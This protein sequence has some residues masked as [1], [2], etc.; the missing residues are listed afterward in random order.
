MIREIVISNSP[1]ILY[2]TVDNQINPLNVHSRNPHFKWDYKIDTYPNSTKMGLSGY[3]IRVGTNSDALGTDEYIG[4]IWDTYQLTTNQAYEASL[5]NGE[6]FTGCDLT[7]DLV[8]GVIYYF[9]VQAYVNSGVFGNKSDWWVGSFKLNRPPT[10]INLAVVPSAPFNSDDLEAYYEFVDDPGDYESPLT[11]IRWYKNGKLVPSLNNKKVVPAAMTIPDDVW[12]FTVEPND[13]VEYGLVYTSPSTAP[14]LNRPPQ[15]SNLAIKPQVPR[16]SDILEASFSLSDPDDDPISATIKWYRNGVEVV[17]VRNSPTVPA[18]ETSYDDEWHFEIIPFDGYDYGATVRSAGVKVVNTPPRVASI[19]VEGQVFPTNVKS[20]NPTISW[21]YKDDDSQTQAA[22]RVVI[23]TKPLRMDVPGSREESFCGPGVDGILGTVKSIGNVAEGN[24]IFDS[25]VVTLGSSSLQYATNDYVPSVSVKAPDFQTFKGYSIQPDLQTISLNDLSGEASLSFTGQTAIYEPSVTYIR[26][27]GKKSLYRLVVDGSAVDDFISEPGTGPNTRTMKATRISADSKVSVVGSPVTPGALAPFTGLSFA[28]LREYD[29]SPSSFQTLSGYVSTEDGGISLV[30]TSGNATTLF[31]LP[32]GTYNIDIEYVTEATVPT[33]TIILSVRSNPILTLPYELGTATRTATVPDVT[34]NTGDQI[35]ISGTRNGGASSARVSKLTFT[36]KQTVATGASLNTGYSYYVAVSVYD[37]IDWSDWATSRFSM[38]GSA[39]SSVSNATGWTIEAKFKLAAALNAAAAPAAVPNCE[40]DPFQGLR[41][42]D[43]T[44]FGYLRLFPDKVQLLAEEPLEYSLDGS[45]YHL[46]RIA[47]MGTDISVYVD[48]ALA[49]DGTGKFTKQTQ[50]RLIEFGDIAGR[51]QT[52]GSAWQAF[53]VSTLGAYAPG[54]MRSTVLEDVTMFPEASVSK[55]K[56]YNDM[57]YVAVDPANPDSST[58]VYRF[59]EG[60][61]AEQRPVLA[62]TRSNVTAVVIDPNKNGN[63]FGTVGKYIGTELGLQYVLGGK[64]FPFDVST[65]MNILPEDNGWILDTNVADID[66]SRY[67]SADF[68]TISTL[69]ETGQKFLKYSQN[70]LGTEWVDKADNSE[71]W[72]V[73]VK[74]KVSDDGNGGN[75]SFQSAQASTSCDNTTPPDLPDLEALG[76]LI[77][78]GTREEV[79]QFFQNGI[80]LKNAKAFAQVDLSSEFTTVRIIGKNDAIAIFSKG[81]SQ[82]FFRRLIVSPD[83]MSTSGSPQ[84]DQERPSV[85]IDMAGR[86]HA[87]WQDSCDGNFAIKYAR[88]VPSKTMAE[89][90]LTSIGNLTTLNFD[91][92]RSSIGLPPITLVRSELKSTYVVS[93]TAS[94]LN[95]GNGP[96]SK[97]DEIIIKDSSGALKKYKVRSVPNDIVVDLD[98]SDDLSLSFANSEFS[99]GSGTGRTWSNSVV[100]SVEQLDST[101]PRLLYHSSGDLFVVY[102]NDAHGSRDVYIRRGKVGIRDTAWDNAIRLTSVSGD[103]SSPDIAEGS[104]G[105]ILVFWIG[106]GEDISTTHVFGAKLPYLDFG[107]ASASFEATPNSV[108]AKNIRVSTVNG[109]ATK[110]SSIIL[111]YQDS[112][113]TLS[114]TSVYA[115]LGSDSDKASLNFGTPVKISNSSGSCKNPS[116]VNCDGTLFYAAW[117]DHSS[118]KPEIFLCKMVATGTTTLLAETPAAITNSCGSSKNPLVLYS[119]APYVL[120]DNDRIRE[121]YSDV[122]ISM[123]AQLPLPPTMTFDRVN[124]V[125]N[126]VAAAVG[127]YKVGL[128][129]FNSV[130]SSTGSVTINVVDDPA[131]LDLGTNLNGAGASTGL[132]V[133]YSPSSVTAVL[134]QQFVYT[135]LAKNSPTAFDV[136]TDVVVSSGGHGLDLR[137][138]SYLGD[139]RRPAAAFKDGILNMVWEARKDGGRSTVYGA[140]H[141]GSTQ[142]FD[143]TVTAYFPLDDD[144]GSNMVE[145]KA[146]NFQGAP[147]VEEAVNGQCFQNSSP[148]GTDLYHVAAPKSGVSLYSPSTEGAFNLGVQGRSFTVPGSLL[149][150]SGAIDLWITP[151]WAS[152]SPKLADHIFFGNASLSDTTSNTLCC[153]VDVLNNFRLRI[154]DA[155]AS[156]NVHETSIA[157][158]DYSWAANESFHLRAVWDENASGVSSLNSTIIGLLGF[159]ATGFACGANGMIFKTTD[160]GATWTRIKTGVTYD[161][162]SIDFVD[163][164]M[165]MACGEYGTILKTSDGGTTWTLLDTGTTADLNGIILSSTTKACAVGAG[166]A[167]YTATGGASWAESAMPAAWVASDLN[168]ISLASSSTMVAVGENGTILRSTNYGASFSLIASPLSVGLNA[169]SRTHQGGAYTTYVVGDSGT[170]MKTINAGSSWTELDI[171]WGIV[172]PQTLLGVSHAASSNAVYVVGGDGTLAKSSDSGGTWSLT[173]TSLANGSFR[174]VEAN[175]WGTGSGAEAVAVGSGGVVMTTSDSGAHQTYHTARSGNLTLYINGKEPNQTRTLDGP[176]AWT[177]TAIPSLVFGDYAVGGT[178]PGLSIFDEL[179]IYGEPP[180]SAANYTK[181]D[182][183]EA[184]LDVS[185]FLQ[186]QN[187][188]K[189]I[190]W[191]SL[192]Q[193][194]ATKSFWKSVKIFTHGS[195]EPLREFCWNAQLGLIDDVVRDISA[196]TG[197]LLWVATENGVSSFDMLAAVTDMDKWLNGEV[198]VSNSPDRFVNYIGLPYGG[199]TSVAADKAGN[200]WVGTAAGLYVIPNVTAAS[201]SANS[202]QDPL[203][204]TAAKT[205]SSLVKMTSFPDVSILTLRAFGDQVFVGTNAGLAIIT[206]GSSQTGTGSSTLSFAINYFTMNDGLPS[207]MVQAIAKEEQSGDVWVGTDKGLVR[208]V[209]GRPIHYDAS[210]GLPSMNIFS[211]A[212]DSLARKFVGT[213]GGMAIIDGTDIASFLPSDG[214]GTGAIQG[215]AID[216]E[217]HAWLATSTSLVES[218]DSQGSRM[219][220]TYDTNDGII[221]YKNITDFQRYYIL[222]GNIPSGACEKARVSV[223]VNGVR[224]GSGYEVDASVPWIMFDTPLGPSDRVQACVEKAWRKVYDFGLNKNRRAYATVK[225]TRNTFNLYKKSFSA[226]TVVLGGNS[227][228]GGRNAATMYTAFVAPLPNGN[229][230]PL[231]SVTTPANNSI[232]A[233]HAGTSVYY[234]VSEQIQ[235]LPTELSGVDMIAMPSTDSSNSST[236]YLQFALSAGAFVYVAYDSR[237]NSL[238]DWLKDFEAVE[239]VF[240]ATDMET[241][242]DASG[243]EKLYVSLAGTN[244]SVYSILNAPEICDISSSIALDNNPPTGCVTSMTAGGSTDTLTLTLTATDAVSGVADMQVSSNTDFTN[245]DSTPMGWTPFQMRYTLQLPASAVPVEQT[246]TDITGNASVMESIDN[247]VLVAIGGTLNTLDKATGQLTLLFDT[248]EQGISSIVKFG[249]VIAVSTTPN[250]KVFTWD[251]THPPVQLGVVNAVSMITFDNNLYIGTKTPLTATLPTETSGDIYI[252]DSTL[253]PTLFIHTLET[254][255]NCFAIFTGN[256]YWGTSNNEVSE[257]D[258]LATTTRNGHRHAFTVPAGQI[259]LT[260]ANGTTTVVNG[261]SHAIVNGV[262]QVADGHVHNLNGRNSGKVFK[263]SSVSGQSTIVHSDKDYSITAI[264]SNSIGTVATTTAPLMF[265]GT[266]PNSKILRYVPDSGVFIKSFNVPALGGISRLKNIG[267]TIYAAADKDIFYFDGTRWQFT[268]SAQDTVKDILGDGNGIFVL[269]GDNLSSTATNSTAATGD[270]SSSSKKT[271]HAYVRFRDAVGNVSSIRAADGSLIPCYAPTITIDTSTGNTT[272]GGS[273]GGDGTPVTLKESHRI[274]EVDDQAKVVF[275][276]TGAEVFLS[277]NRVEQEI[278]TYESEIFNGTSSLVQWESIAWDAVTPTGT[279]ITL[280][281]RTAATASGVASASYGLEMTNPTGND[282]TNLIGQFLQFRA[283]LTVN[284]PGVSSPE[285]RS[286][287]IRLKTSDATHYFTTNFKLPDNVVR[288]LLTYNGCINPPVTDVVFG[289]CGTDSTD[290]SDYYIIT[291]NRIFEL[292]TEQQQP[293]LRVGIKMISSPTSVPVVDEFALLVSLA[294]NAVARLGQAGTPGGTFP[295]PI[296]GPTR[297]VITEPVQ[298][299]VHTVQFDA[300]ITDQTAVN[301]QTSISGSHSHIIVAGVLQIAAGHTHRWT[302]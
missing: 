229:M 286:V 276:L 28:P 79:V 135:I 271:L 263:L 68:L 59:Q 80:R 204:S 112:A 194:V 243:D 124:G 92:V 100:L 87:A 94:F 20:G 44:S 66:A 265:I 13:G 274:V 201:Q 181:R 262:V 62:I 278:G 298:G 266:Y 246:I 26:E 105:S 260:Q 123:V 104:D 99:I 214:L 149:S 86:P 222:G 16:T 236:A 118:S 237:A 51:N 57:L 136:L 205:T 37:G 198:S 299:H 284:V 258:V 209:G 143:S 166:T 17:A 42:Y 32:S 73:E 148:I 235:T 9:Q 264:A 43:G 137:V 109:G 142:T 19:M 241:F 175:F 158:A 27:Q 248:G 212:T 213:A 14:V 228:R 63:P 189:R 67:L 25:G 106:T 1:T 139:N 164:S 296:V 120:Y 119:K 257:N 178:H 39:W 251:G 114:D 122:Y 256:L 40:S 11:K 111:T 199:A 22:F 185:G 267:G 125:I 15:A 163:A 288:G 102:D 244:G 207:N 84:G 77:N 36:P 295:Q 93:P 48:G 252:V 108:N 195:R 151:Y 287:D 156:N 177:P 192:S 225:T 115:V 60:A 126:G 203:D 174:S 83:A 254:S 231:A 103:S 131:A 23:G 130:G 170:A 140:S 188:I 240:R 210:K 249:S 301:G 50:S 18:S 168:D 197:N 153:G 150:K 191:G 253:A 5:N 2:A 245:E 33:P 89:G 290:F 216:K 47:A 171:G 300:G 6:A 97:G 179:V 233:A 12:Y 183:R 226:G 208:Y 157:P 46:Y 41:F 294:N 184:Q 3:D 45:A 155:D 281:V 113:T 182:F 277:G 247:A 270:N 283:T 128:I 261:H 217:Q 96:V 145:N 292:P 269:K 173:E 101:N 227:S 95:G 250:G 147:F 221:G 282:L 72:T 206:P 268:G 169:I 234:N 289:V 297:T 220:V 132:P 116:A 141:D 85:A 193:L 52:L 211:L 21:L 61:A 259:W 121:G 53:R 88:E 110:A 54:D 117:E 187:S 144:S 129:A 10:A 162:F 223:A 302:L 154:V 202:S 238:P 75:V 218:Y 224:I 107:K 255:V 273:N 161:L 7:K 215:I 71:G 280:A 230:S 34:I 190:E 74:V 186:G 70:S 38:D 76:L 138:E 56:E 4:D 78:D 219:F 64:P 65:N 35:K 272:G 24:D 196:G 279:S 165:G 232:V 49:I 167:I 58:Q 98:T 152:N 134:G 91:S 239:A 69:A 285:L 275:S 127:T 133:I 291:P 200:A 176:F 31:S 30:G 160:G 293:N 159:P 172:P 55:L 242:T 146:I 8:V 82:R 180:P 29:L 81:D 90:S